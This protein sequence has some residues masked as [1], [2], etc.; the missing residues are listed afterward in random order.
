MFPRLCVSILAL[1]AALSAAPLPVR[2]LHLSSPKPADVPRMTKFIREVL[3]K[4]GVNTLVLEINYH[5]QFKSHP[6][7]AD[8]D[9]LSLD[10]AR[11]IATA[12]R[13]SNVKLIPLVN[14]LGHQ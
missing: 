8:A 6:E 14:L 3:P 5:Y 1:A 10:D 9:A 12:A 13:E 2:G 11:A 7:V 4:E